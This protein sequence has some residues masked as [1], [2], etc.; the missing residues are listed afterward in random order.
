MTVHKN[1]KNSILSIIYYT[2]RTSTTPKIVDFTSHSGS[3]FY[4]K[5]GNSKRTPQK[6]TETSTEG[7]KKGPRE[8]Q[9]TPKEHRESA[10]EP[11]GAPREPKLTKKSPK[12]EGD[13][14]KASCISPPLGLSPSHSIPKGNPITKPPAACMSRRFPEYIYIY[15][16][17][18][19]RTGKRR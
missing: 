17:S 5:N 18:D 16:C 13:F 19:K 14:H 9:K 2:S 8:P 3:K 7:T 11:P 1:T 15:T 4:E 10:R 6:E 12:S